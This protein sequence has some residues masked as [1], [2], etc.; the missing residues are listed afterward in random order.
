MS[1]NRRVARAHLLRPYGP[2]QWLVQPMPDGEARDVD[3]EVINA[4]G[5]HVCA[6]GENVRGWEPYTAI[7]EVHGDGGPW[8]YLA[9]LVADSR[10]QPARPGSQRR[11]QPTSLYLTPADREIIASLVERTGL[12]RTAVIR[13]A[14]RELARRVGAQAD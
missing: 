1:T 14:L 2:P 13:L 9:E 4:L 5:Y 3:L 6:D 10:G 7:I 12:G 11:Q 8:H